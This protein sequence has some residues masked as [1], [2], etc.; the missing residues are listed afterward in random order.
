MEKRSCEKGD[1]MKIRNAACY[2][3]S[4]GPK[5]ALAHLRLI[6]PLQQ[7]GIRIINGLESGQPDDEPVLNGDLVV[8]QRDFPKLFDCYQQVIEIARQGKKPV[9]FDLDDLLFYLPENHPIRLYYAPS[10]LPM[11]QALMEA[12]YAGHPI[13]YACLIGFDKALS[14]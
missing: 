5:D 1:I 14:R 4:L 2:S 13:Y 9:V 11:F 6:A 12:D 3:I 8:V 10:L 7:A